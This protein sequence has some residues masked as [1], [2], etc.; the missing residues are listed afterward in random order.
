MTRSISSRRRVRHAHFI[1]CLLL[2][3]SIAPHDMSGPRPSVALMSFS[4]VALMVTLLA[5]SGYSQDP[6]SGWL[7]YAMG[8][9][10]NGSGIITYIEAKW[11]VPSDPV[12]KGAFFSPWFGIESSDN[13]NLIQPVNP[14]DGRSLHYSL[15]TTRL[16]IRQQSTYSH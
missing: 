16:L 9:S 3:A 14:W 10:P 13:L 15:R 6:A 5:A 1:G 2:F 12:K 11:V 7:G 4:V 8:S